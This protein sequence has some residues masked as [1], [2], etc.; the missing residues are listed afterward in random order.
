MH[1]SFP[2]VAMGISLPLCMRNVERI[3]KLPG[4]TEITAINY[5]MIKPFV[6]E[7]VRAAS[8]ISSSYLVI[9]AVNYAG[10][11][12]SSVRIYGLSIF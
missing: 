9:L 6:H 7:Q 3:H 12:L 2:G 5:N 10:S 8:Y 11:L 4:E 1:S